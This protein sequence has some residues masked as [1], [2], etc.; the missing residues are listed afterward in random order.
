MFRDESLSSGNCQ[1]DGGLTQV[2]ASRQARRCST[3][4]PGRP[5]AIEATRLDPTMLSPRRFDLL[6]G[7][8]K[9][10]R[11]D[12][13]QRIQINTLLTVANSSFHLLVG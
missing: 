7:N 11:H 9:N 2:E 10:L 3:Q 4:F 5:I 1:T 13:G 8:T 6:R 12:L